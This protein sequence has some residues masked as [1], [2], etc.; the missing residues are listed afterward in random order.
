M[1]V[2]EEMLSVEPAK[3][4]KRIRKLKDAFNQAKPSICVERARLFTESFRETE[5]QPRILRSAKAFRHVCQNIPVTIFD[6]ELI[7]G[8]TG[9]FRRS[10]AMCPE[11]SWQWVDNEL[12]SFPTR[13]QDP[14]MI[15]DDQIKTLREEVFPYWK[16]KTLEE[17][18]LAQVP[19]ETAKLIVDTG[20][21]DNDSKWRNG[22]GEITPDY[23]DILFRK[24]FNGICEEAKA[25]LQELEPDDSDSMDK[26]NFYS[27][28]IETSRGIIEL[29]GRYADKASIMAGVEQDLVRKRELLT[30]SEN[31]RRVP[32]EPPR[33]F[34]EAVQFVWFTQMGSIMAENSLALNIG[35]FDQFMY[36]CYSTDMKSGSID[37]GLAQELV[38]CLWIKF[39]EW[40]WAISRNTANYFAGYNSFQNLTIGGRKRN[41]TDAVNELS[42]MCLKATADVKTHQPGLSV[43][44]DANTPQEFVME[45][46]KLV[47]MGTGF[48]AIHN[49]RIG[50][51][52][53]LAA[54]LSQEDARDW[55]NCGCVVPHFRKNGE[56]T[57]AVNINLAAAMEYALND[58]RSRMTGEQMGLKTGDPDTFKTFGD[59]EKAYYAQLAYL[60]KHAK[61]G[62]ILAQKIHAELIPRPYIS[63]LVDGPMQKGSDLSKG[64]A[65]YPVG[66]VLTGIGLADSANSFSVV[67]R[68]VFDEGKVTISELNR[69]LDNNWEGFDDLRQM[70]LSCPKY[71]NDDDYVDQFAIDISDFYSKEITKD[72]DFWGVHFNSAFMGISNYVPM[73]FPIGATPDGRLAGSPLTEGCS[74]HAGTDTTSPTATMRSIA[75]LNHEGH[76]GGTL[77]NM[78]FNPDALKSDKDLVN[79]SNLI[80]SYFELGA[81]HVQFNVISTETLKDAQ[82]HPENYQDLLVRVAGYSTRFVVLSKEMQDAIIERNTYTRV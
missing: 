13:K 15:T 45:V 18:F 65:V 71:G 49:D 20:I 73:G 61:R 55:N 62:N 54:G 25:R 6:D 12:D 10:A 60:I 57:S 29:A 1:L 31:C 30:I 35:R 38:E 75:K 59:L 56:W 22:V 47:R 43:R 63:L 9:K 32:A 64:S 8:T 53:L 19:A 82:K 52:M 66:S 4:T 68:L 23:Q 78:K 48:P 44:I 26:I 5:G 2:P 72:N 80:R 46:A 42:Y 24:G 41:G 69:A 81:F 16:G 51:E 7:V 77:L 34:W 79:L 33:T 40:I 37:Q 50:S 76:S 28:A 36:P 74:P 58:G 27:A 39:S 17:A 67:K 14:Y 11:M 3:M 21:L 70:A